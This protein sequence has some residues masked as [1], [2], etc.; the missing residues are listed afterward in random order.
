GTDGAIYISDWFDSMVG[1]H[2]MTDSIGRGRIYRIA[3]K[4]RK[5]EKPVIDLSTTEGQ[6]AALLNPAVNVRNSGFVLL[7]EQGDQVVDDVKQI[8]DS[9]NAYH[10]ARAIWL[11]A[12]LGQNGVAE[13][14]AMLD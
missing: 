6:I 3:P 12:N 11:L 9:D 2:R 13:V 4:D 10:Q 7:A 8:L 5:L 14:E 1:G